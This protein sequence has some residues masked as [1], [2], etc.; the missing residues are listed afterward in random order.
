MITLGQLRTFCRE[1]ASTD[2]SDTTANRE[3]MGWI[4]SAL[5]R[6]YKVGGWDRTLTERK[7]TVFPEETRDDVVVTQGS[8]NLSSVTGF[9]AK[10]L[11][12]RWELAIEGYGRSTFELGTIGTPATTATLREGDEWVGSSGTVDVRFLNSRFALPKVK[13]VHR[14]EVVEV[15]LPVESLP[16]EEFDRRKQTEPI[17]SGDPRYCTWRRGFLEIWPAPTTYRKLSI[18]YQREFTRIADDADDDDEV[19]W[20]EE[21]RDVLEKAILVQAALTQGENSPISYSMA[22]REFE[23]ALKSSKSFSQ[24]PEMTGAMGDKRP[25]SMLRSNIWLRNVEVDPS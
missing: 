3:F 23:T 4:N 14:V 8:L 5:D 24:R 1:V 18:T 19:D 21:E 20:D 12:G 7:I 17:S 15:G 9:L 25:P 22:T 16:P 10:W 2:N 13:N 6:L 11:T